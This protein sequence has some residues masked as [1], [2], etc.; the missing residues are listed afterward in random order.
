LPIKSLHV[1]LGATGV[2]VVRQTLARPGM[3]IVGAIEVDPARVGRD[4]GEVCRLRRRLGVTVT[5]DL[6]QAVKSGKPDIAVV[7]TGSAL[8][9]VAPVVEQLLKLKVPVISTA[10]E[11]A[12][13]GRA[14]AARAKRI[15]ALAKRGRVA[16]LG[17]G[18]NPG[19]VMDALPIM[20]TAVSSRVDGVVVERVLDARPR[21]ASIQRRFGL[22]LDVD[23]FRAGLE[24]RT[25]GHLGFAESMAM[26]ADA[27][28]WKLDRV[29]VDTQ[30]LVADEPIAGGAA[31]VAVGH[32]RGLVQ[33]AIGHRKGRAVITLHLEA[34][35]D[36]PEPRDTIRIAGTPSLDVLIRGGIPGDTATEAI[37]VNTIPKLL[38]AP[39]GLRTMRDMVLPAF[40]AAAKPR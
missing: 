1:G 39:P 22:G 24:S 36:A 28:S 31:S 26:I 34:N 15:D 7:C 25:V 11:L 20:L 12:Y 33:R 29:D 35:L 23:V 32:V 14:H 19:F 4:L 27:L 30:P 10:E 21:R 37:V 38:Q 16:V 13:P 3:S 9:E 2:G 6:A 5:S 17:T 18:V 40:W 8:A